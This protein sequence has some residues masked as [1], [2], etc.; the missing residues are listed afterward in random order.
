MFCR[1]LWPLVSLRYLLILCHSFCCFL[2]LDS[3][4]NFELE[5][6]Q[7]FTSLLS[8]MPDDQ[9]TPPS[10]PRLVLRQ[11]TSEAP[12]LLLSP[13][14]TSRS[15]PSSSLTSP[16]GELFACSHAGCQASFNEFLA[17]RAHE[18]AEHK[19]QCLNFCLRCRSRQVLVAL[20]TSSNSLV[21]VLLGF[22][23]MSPCGLPSDMSGSARAR[24]PSAL[25]ASL[26]LSLLVL[27]STRRSWQ[28][29]MLPTQV[30][31]PRSLLAAA[32]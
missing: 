1:V 13:P 23:H 9:A 17:L 14:R 12:L 30:A 21:V 31:L 11:E 18:V 4:R 16:L 28:H 3:Q 10:P 8:R 24:S 19:L 27:L 32:R 29:K 7:T 2:I 25:P 22:P 6:I 15:A 26:R 5:L 20:P